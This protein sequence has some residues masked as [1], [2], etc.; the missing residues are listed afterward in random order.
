MADASYI[1]V[2][3]IDE[4]F[5]LVRAHPGN[6]LFSAGGTD[7]QV[8]LKQELARAP[9]IVDLSGIPELRGIRSGP[10]GLG[11][12]SMTTLCEIA[13]SPAVR[14]WCP[15]I[16]AAAE[17]IATPVLRMTA[18]VGGNLLVANRCT[19]FNQSAAWRASAGSC[20]RDAGD[21]CLVTGGHDKCFS[22]HVSDLAPALIA[23]EGRVVVRDPQ[24]TRET[25]LAD[26]YVTDGLRAQA[27]LGVDAILTEVRFARR[28]RH[29]WYRKL[30][31]RESVDYTS[32]T[33]A[34]ALYEDHHVRVCI[35]GVS[36][37]PVL[38][39]VAAGKTS[40]ESV[41]SLARRACKAVD[42]DLLPLSYRREMIDT[43][44]EA[45]WRELGEI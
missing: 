26:I 22:R 5:D 25:A 17:S 2:G 10:A 14:S 18:T 3:N 42:N 9:L 19:W 35:G 37:S 15:M 33:V 11:I 38:L 45:L 31:R 7:L 16:A 1:V 24:S 39:D 13:A 28:P 41:K 36:M 32:L 21:A 40:L 29:W 27:N 23:L 44:L 6:Y 30:R 12:G 20:L 43:F 4:A 8:R 34:G